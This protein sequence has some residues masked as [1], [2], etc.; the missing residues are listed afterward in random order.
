[1]NLYAKNF[2]APLCLGVFFSASGLVSVSYADVTEDLKSC[3]NCH[4]EDGA[5]TDPHVPIIGGMSAIVLEDA[6]TAYRDEERSCPEYEYPEG[7]NKGDKTTMCK[8]AADISE[9]DTKALAEHLAGKP[10]VRAKQEFD[11]ALAEKG[12]EVHDELCEKCHSEAGSLASD[13]AG[14]LA[15]QWMPYLEDTFKD[16]S[17]G[18]RPMTKKMKKKMDK[19]DDASTKALINYYG[20]FK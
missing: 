4:G 7:P 20:S 18:K 1:M 17:D 14:M 8:I 3:A 10:F 6:M 16:Y 11:A 19:L 15:G 13:D 5:S 12:K 2:L 9:K